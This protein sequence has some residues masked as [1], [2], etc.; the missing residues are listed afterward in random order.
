MNDEWRATYRLQVNGAFPLSEAERRLPYLARLGISHVYLSPCLQAAPGSD[1]GYDVTDPTRISADLGGEEAWRRFCAAAHRLG[2]GILLDVVPNHMA[3]SEHNPWWDDLLAHGPFSVY[4]SFFDIVPERNVRWR[5]HLPVLGRD[6]GETLAAR[7]FS[8]DVATGVPRLRLGDR[9]WPLTPASW[10][11]LLPADI[12]GEQ[13]LAA[14]APAGA[15]EP[16]A[17]D[18][19]RYQAAAIEAGRRLPEAAAIEEQA[20]KIAAHPEHL[21]ALLEEQWY[22]LHYWKREGEIANYR[23]FFDVGSL[24]ALRAEESEVFAASHARV[25]KLIRDQDVQGIRVDHPDGLSRPRE[26]LIRLREL[27]GEGVIVVEKILE[28]EERLR[29]DW[30]VDG[31]VGYDFLSKVNRLWMDEQKSDALSAIY[32]DF[33]GHSVNLPKVIR[34]KKS[35]IIEDLFNADL[36]RLTDVALRIARSSWRTHDLSRTQLRSALVLMTVLM[37]VY[38]TYLDGRPVDPADRDVLSAVFAQS[39]AQATGIDRA[40]FDFL[41]ECL[42]G[43]S[44]DPAH[45]ELVDRWQQMTPAVM[46]KGVEDTAYYCYDRLVSCNEVGAQ[47]S[48]LGISSEKF[49]EF[50]HHLAEN[51]PCSLLATST[52]DNKRSEDVRARISVLTEDT[53]R[54]AEAL[55]EWSALNQPGWR[56]RAPDRHLEYLLY[57]TLVGAWPIDEERA[58]NYLRKAIREAKIMTSWREP[59]ESYETTVQEFLMSAFRTPAFLASLEKFVDALLLP[60][61]LNGLAQTLIKLTAPGVPD[62]YQGSEL[63]DLSLVDPDNRRPVDFDGREQLLQKLRTMSPGNVL[64][65][66]NSGAPKMWLIQRALELRHRQPKWFGRGASYQPVTARGARVAHVLAFLR[67]GSVLTLV[68]RFSHSLRGDWGDTSVTLPAG[69]WRSALG[70]AE[71][72]GE[73]SVGTLLK[74]FPVALLALEP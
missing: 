38:R 47:A 4:R 60:G 5:V 26:Y 68:P 32:A 2:L 59:N 15:T 41:E 62:L 58:W 30:A 63:W 1:H 49:H 44:G 19:A 54:W 53:A 14:L 64:E 40:V 70:G 13:L 21:H 25:A 50:C 3:A 35:L 18:R 45:R 9:T 39:R 57:Q 42:A 61:R 66:W 7:E 37:P 24:A 12:L 16:S 52:H 33:T 73:V 67:A 69:R 46:A 11:H 72:A 8:I 56:G 71:A 6:Y 29:R 10:R 22:G 20:K 31:T 36:E 48:A 74:D 65:D 28:N 51:W 27:V 55:H 17:E 23:R 34:E 43:N